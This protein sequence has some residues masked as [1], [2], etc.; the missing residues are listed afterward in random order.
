MSAR[1]L[2]VH[3]YFSRRR[4]DARPDLPTAERQTRQRH[5]EYPR[6]QALRRHHL[7]HELSRGVST[8]GGDEVAGEDEREVIM[9]RQIDAKFLSLYRLV[10]RVS[11]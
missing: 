8:Q 7:R 1:R 6:P 10:R 9:R 3:Y 5:P 4:N 11:G 2:L